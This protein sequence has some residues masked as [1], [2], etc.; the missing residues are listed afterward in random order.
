MRSLRI[1]DGS[2]SRSNRQKQGYRV[3]DWNRNH[4]SSNEAGASNVDIACILDG[5]REEVD[6]PE[7]PDKAGKCVERA[8]QNGISSGGVVAGNR[9][10]T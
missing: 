5:V 4:E 1:Q 9:P 10:V 7:I 2:R 8:S 3:E 6:D